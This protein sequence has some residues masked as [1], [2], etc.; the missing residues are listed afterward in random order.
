VS[1]PL[2]SDP[3]S[4]APPSIA[5]PSID[6]EDER[7]AAAE[8]AVLAAAARDL[9]RDVE[10]ARRDRDAAVTALRRT[11]TRRSMRVARAVDDR[12]RA[13][14]EPVRALRRRV[15]PPPVARGGSGGAQL[16]V[17]AGLPTP[18]AFR[19]SFLERLDRPGELRVAILGP[20]PAG[21]GSP[22]EIAAAIP[23]AIAAAL[24][25]AVAAAGWTLV[26]DPASA[27][28]VFVADPSR[29]LR[30]LPRG[31]VLVA[32]VAD[33]VHWVDRSRLDDVDLVVVP[34]ASV[35]TALEG[36]AVLAQ[37]VAAIGAE[38]RSGVAPTVRWPD[39][40]G[41]GLEAALRRWALGLRI[42]IAIGIPSW[43]VAEAWGDLH[44]ARG[45]QRQLERRGHA[46]RV[47]LLPDWTDRVSARDD[48][49]I[50]IFGLS[51][52]AVLPGQ[53]T[54]LWVI[55][56]PD[57][58]SA[59][60]LAGADRIY[61]ASDRT[62]ERIAGQTDKP[63][64]ALHQATDPER[65][66][67]DPTGPEHGVLFV[68]NTRGVRRRIVEDLVP[69][70][71]D[72]AVYGQG[73]SRQFPDAPFI[74][75]EHVPNADLNRWYGSAGVVLNDHWPD[76]QAEGFLSNRL[77]D[78]LAAGGFVISDAVEGMD[79]EFDGG[80]VSVTSAGELRWAI[81]DH[82]ADPDRRRRLA[83]RG[84]RAVL[85][86][87]TFTHRIDTILADLAADL[88]TSPTAS[89]AIEPHAGNG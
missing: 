1:D 7:W 36:V 49:V 31:P 30:R 25:A 50:H 35:A 19:R 24:P 55:S 78:A 5:P 67:V 65:F 71:L 27:D 26:A 38:D 9:E 64:T 29:D 14:L 3:P 77:Y 59:A 82:L 51:E 72:L 33:A 75:G 39:G 32:V 16:R 74:R 85:E 45:L 44:F 13:G 60:M 83:E 43:D 37:N 34:D 11:R 10:R 15:S 48:V 86:R 79:E 28:V 12:L 63:V 18:A 47:H 42:G 21:S 68:G 23:A 88:A 46:T 89:R 73:W 84:R 54:I 57:R 8:R 70:T 53:R 61:V 52:R 80:V 2:S 4:S 58:V 6:H 22:A 41:D 66:R 87:H 40:T 76:M 56:H 62:A 81:H 20:D 69:T 17:P